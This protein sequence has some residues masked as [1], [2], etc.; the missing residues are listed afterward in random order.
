[1]KKWSGVFASVRLNRYALDS[2]IAAAA[3]QREIARQQ[4]H[5]THEE[6]RHHDVGQVVDD[7]VEAP[8]VDTRRQLA[9]TRQAGEPAVHAVDG[10]RRDHPQEGGP[11]VARRG[12]LQRGESHDGAAGGEGMDGPR[13]GARWYAAHALSHVP[14]DDGMQEW[15]TDAN[16]DIRLDLWLTRHADAGSRGRAAGWLEKGKV[17][18]NGQAA[19]PDDAGARLQAGDRVGVWIDRPGSARASDRAVRGQHHLFAS[20]PKTRPSS[21]STRPRACS[22]S[23]CPTG[24]GRRRR[25]S[26]CCPARSI[27][28]RAGGLYVV[29]RIDRDTSGLVLFARTADARDALKDQFERRTPTRVYQAV[30]LGEVTPERG[31]WTDRLAW[32]AEAFRQRRAHG[33]DARGKDAVA[34]YAVMEQY[35]DAALVEVSLVTGKRNQI[36]VQA[37][38]RGHPL[39]GERQY[40]FGSPAGA[41]G[42]APHRAAGAARVAPGFRASVDR[43]PDACSPPDAPGRPRTCACLGRLPCDSQLDGADVCAPLALAEPQHAQ[44][45]AREWPRTMAS[46]M[47]A[48]RRPCSASITA[49]KPERHDDLG[50]ERDVER[51]LRVARALQRAG[52]DERDGDEEARH[53]EV[54]QQLGADLEHVRLA[55]AEDAEQRPRHGDEGEA[56]H[57]RPRRARSARRPWRPRC[58]ARACRRRGSG[59]RRSPSRP[60]GRPTST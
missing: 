38:M 6:R 50:D 34:H 33:R 24:P 17:F 60:S 22:S 13:R 4:A 52:V 18:L 46:Q 9:D 26:T 59:P 10:G 43:P 29:H 31:T 25:S 51:A 12:R 7:V 30:L 49:Q 20:W 41:A 28:M 27:T 21:S 58:C 5:R 40:R 47:S 3:G 15:V 8:A 55:H 45:A 42:P 39:L 36:R 54:A 1:M 16:A 19:D 32:D 44:R 48:A 37:G 23:R 2:S 56:D 57:R 53:G 11:V 35:A 14:R